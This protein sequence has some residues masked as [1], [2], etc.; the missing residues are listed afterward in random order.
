MESYLNSFNFIKRIFLYQLLIFFVW[1]KFDDIINSQKE[2]FNNVNKL[3]TYSGFDDMIIKN[4]PENDDILFRIILISILTITILS[5]LN[6]NVMKFM[7][8]LI[9]IFIGLIYYNPS[10]KID[11]LITKNIIT[12]ILNDYHSIPSKEFL[13]YISA[14]IA[15]IY[16]SIKDID[17]FNYISCYCFCNSCENDRKRKNKKKCKINCQFEFDSN[18]DSNNDNIGND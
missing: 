7:S 6:F 12:I 3:L 4:I 15:I 9:S 14:G 8:G 16:Q 17:F 11:E 2:F 13:I 5:I 1:N 18:C 10:I